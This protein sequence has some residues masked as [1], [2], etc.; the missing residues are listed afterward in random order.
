MRSLAPLSAEIPLLSPVPVTVRLSGRS[1]YE[2]STSAASTSGAV[3][4]PAVP[5][6]E[7]AARTI[8]C[9]AAAPV[10]SKI[11][12]AYARSLSRGSPGART[13]AP[14]GIFHTPRT[15]VHG[16]APRDD[17]RRAPESNG[18]ERARD[19]VRLISDRLIHE[20][21]RDVKVPT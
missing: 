16:Q 14:P 17:E 4:W 1:G 20:L 12:P 5:N 19:P 3:M 8:A 18:D 7:S 15:A 11:M 2:A 10:K 9:D 21:P 6:H 13:V